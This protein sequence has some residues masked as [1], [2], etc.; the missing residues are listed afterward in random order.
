[1]RAED[2]QVMLFRVK[3]LMVTVLP[4]LDPAA[5]GGT[6][7]SCT[8]EHDRDCK[9][10]LDVLKLTPYAHVDPPYL[11]ELRVVL[12]HA[13]ARSGVTVPGGRDVKDLEQQ[14]RPR[15]LE[16]IEVLEQ[17]LTGALEELASQRKEIETWLDENPGW[18]PKGGTE[19][20]ADLSR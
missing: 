4:Q 12:D 8:S 10:S 15:R 18:V 6:V 7:G 11:K 16:D 13:L 20:A 1:M 17:H 2:R 19:S 9:L 3:D 5:D 14:M